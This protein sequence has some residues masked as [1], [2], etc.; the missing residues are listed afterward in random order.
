MKVS[1]LTSGFPHGFTDDF[2]QCIK[3]YNINIVQLK[4]MPYWTSFKIFIFTIFIPDFN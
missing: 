4:R 3:E 1:I 2:I